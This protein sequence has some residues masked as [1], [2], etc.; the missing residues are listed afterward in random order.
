MDVKFNNELNEVSNQNIQFLALC[1]DPISVTAEPF[2][3]EDGDY[4]KGKNLLAISSEYTCIGTTNS[5]KVISNTDIHDFFTNT[6]LQDNDKPHNLCGIGK[7]IEFDNDIL[8]VRVFKFDE[9]SVFVVV[10]ANGS[11]YLVYQ[12]D[13][14]WASHKQSVEIEI[15]DI[16]DLASTYRLSQN[17]LIYLNKDKQLFQLEFNKKALTLEKNKILSDYKGIKDFEYKSDLGLAFIDEDNLYISKNLKTTPQK[18]S[19][20]DLQIDS[21]DFYKVQFISNKCISVSF[22]NNDEGEIEEELDFGA[23][24]TKIIFFEQDSVVVTNAELVAE[25]D[26]TMPDAYNVI[27]TTLKDFVPQYS[28][29]SVLGTS[30]S[31]SVQILTCNKDQVS[32]EQ[33][34]EDQHNV[35]LPMTEEGDDTSVR[36]LSFSL[37][38]DFKDE[39]TRRL[40]FEI[41]EKT[42]I[43]LV[44]TSDLKLLVYFAVFVE[45]FKNEKYNADETIKLFESG[46]HIKS[47]TQE[48]DT[49]SSV[50]KEQSSLDKFITDDGKLKPPTKVESP[51]VEE[52][53]PSGMFSSMA[54]IIEH[55]S[56]PPVFG[57]T[58]DN[59]FSIG[60]QGFSPFGDFG[61]NVTLGKETVFGQ[62]QF[63]ANSSVI[64]GD[65]SEEK[66]EPKVNAFAGFSNKESPF[67][68]LNL[69]S[70]D[71]E[72]DSFGEVKNDSKVP[73]NPFASASSSKESPF[74]SFGQKASTSLNFS[75]VKDIPPSVANTEEK[76]PEQEP[77]VNDEVEKLQ[78][79][80]SEDKN[81]D[82]PFNNSYT[83]INTSEDIDEGQWVEIGDE[84]SIYI[85]QTS[86]IHEEPEELVESSGKGDSTLDAHAIED[87][88]S[89]D[90]AVVVENPAVETEPKDVVSRGSQ[91]NREMSTR[92]VQTPSLEYTEGCVVADENTLSSEVLNEAYKF[93]TIEKMYVLDEKTIW[94]HRD[95]DREQKNDGVFEMMSKMV[96]LVDNHIIT[97]NMNIKI[98]N[99]N[100]KEHQKSTYEKS[101][102]DAVK[103]GN[104]NWRFGEIKKIN[105]IVD[106]SF[107]TDV[108]D[109]KKVHEMDTKVADIIKNSLLL[110]HDLQKSI[111][112]IGN[113]VKTQK[114]L[115][116]SNLEEGLLSSHE[117]MIDG[118]QSKLSIVE[119]TL[120]FIKV[121]LALKKSV[122]VNDI[123]TDDVEAF[124]NTKTQSTPRSEKII[125]PFGVPPKRRSPKYDLNTR[126]FNEHKRQ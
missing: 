56:K 46:L 63:N 83:T 47:E 10:L 126:L 49:K 65:G 104:V 32:L 16:N 33:C 100:V 19:L 69:K 92:A 48:S 22:T 12:K 54:N 1:K 76:K 121:Y 85:N 116:L 9:R 68:A 43:L 58:N 59:P 86:D 14:Q 60:G 11:L 101:S 79:S 17:E 91:I 88:C 82:I 34:F 64:A 45:E 18:Y 120:Y 102:I 51:P 8:D 90:E 115:K 52:Q 77:N 114:V 89:D 37:G 62:P 108:L 15:D 74:A 122:E 5:V 2:V 28:Y 99:E 55:A 73:V 112:D 3:T 118:I 24:E 98:L 103:D 42:P 81:N 35:Y 105:E 110:K 61:K 4:I 21:K 6:V 67:A 70:A 84:K 78:A 39:L 36:G 25:A 13:E 23:L 7:D 57:K 41:K 119:K 125:K 20:K 113:Q 96:H 117:T 40:E 95:E 26:A 97:L 27:S 75:Q 66:P 72:I 87:N 30:K 94:E 111:K 29:F 71:N 53:K 93:P 38:Y 106:S 31:T 50:V 107:D 44:L 124:L 80:S 109:L 123:T